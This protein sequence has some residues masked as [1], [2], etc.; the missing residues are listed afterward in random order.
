[1]T[2]N[3]VSMG[4]LIALLLSLSAFASF[5]HAADAADPVTAGTQ[6]ERNGGGVQISTWQ[7]KDQAGVKN[8]G[9]AAFQGW[10]EKGLD[11]HLAWEN[12]IGYWHRT[13]TWSD[14]DFTGTTNHELQTHLVPTLT[15][16]RLYPF[17]TPTDRV[18]PYLSAGAGVVLGFEQ[19]KVTG[20]FVS[21][22]PSYQMHT[23]LGLRAGAGLDLKASDVFGVMVGG[24]FE[25]ASFG[26][27]K[28]GERL[29][30][31]FGFDAGLTYRFQYR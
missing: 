17:T 23:G 11:L 14:V 30:K 12:T 16:L 25:S 29:Y 4:R 24:H 27:E 9:M 5:A 28:P 3:R 1:M 31:G 22:N 10:F 6:R 15:A 18:E 26:E 13:S 20:T 2:T 7:P 19:D 21:A 8:T